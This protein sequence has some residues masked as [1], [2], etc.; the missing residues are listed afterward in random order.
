[1]AKRDRQV[2]QSLL[3][4]LNILS[5]FSRKNPELRLKEISE[6]LDMPA[7]T[8]H[9]LLRTLQGSDYI[10]Q[11]PCSGKYRLGAAAFILGTKVPTINKLVETSLPYIA[12]LATKYNAATHV[13][14]ETN[15]YVLCLEKIEPPTAI[16]NSPPRGERHDLHLTGLGK[17]LLAF[18]P[19]PKQE[20][21]IQGMTFRRATPKSI[22]NR[23]DLL[24]ELMLASRQ[25]YAIDN[26]ESC[27]NLYCFA[28]PVLQPDGSA[29]GAISVSLNSFSFPDSASN[30]ISDVK[31][32][33]EKI[34]SSLYPK[35]KKQKLF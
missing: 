18:A 16:V 23:K 22:M 29:V 8:T 31:Q 6:K 28:A 30:I 32:S 34:S 24:A 20:K 9:R 26:C 11:D 12:R 21:L 33:A 1:M 3:K 7:S 5:L 15:G 35:I 27:E 14:I 13:A 10:T 17:C 2:I 4:A 19:Q 25:G